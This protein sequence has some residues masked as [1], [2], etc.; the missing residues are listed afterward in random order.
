MNP[1]LT[2]ALVVGTIGVIGA[3][4]L[5][6]ASK[7]FAVT[8]NEQVKE[9]QMVLPNGNCGGCG[10]AGCADYARAIAEGAPGNLCAVGGQAVMEKISAIMGQDL[11]KAKQYR[12][13][14]CCQGDE[15]HTQKR[16]E[17]HGLE[18]CAACNVL[19]SGH[20]SCPFGCIGF[21]D[22]MKA[23]KFGA[24]SI[25]NGIAKIDVNKCTGCGSCKAACPK[26]IIFMYE[27]TDVPKRVIMCSNIKKAL[28]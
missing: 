7:I 25:V 24:I 13:M 9:I 18:T 4:L 15:N 6:V 5:V 26:E 12:A 2:A 3:I 27:V 1:I 10:F 22:C 23:C 17:Y 19:Y 14:I 11:G 16:Y 28:D 21:G 20:S 8:E